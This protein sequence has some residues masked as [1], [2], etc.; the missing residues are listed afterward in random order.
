MSK[1]VIQIIILILICKIGVAQT[2]INTDSILFTT[3]IF[4]KEQALEVALEFDISEFIDQK[5]T[6]QYVPAIL[7][8]YIADSVNIRDSVRLKS[9]G[10][11]RLKKCLFPPYWINIKNANHSVDSNLKVNKIKVVSHCKASK[12]HENYLLKEFVAYKVFN[13]IT[14]YSFKVRLLKINYLDTGKERKER[15]NWAFMIEPEEVL[16]E[17]LEAYPLKLEKVSYS[18]TDTL[19]TTILSFFQYMIGNLDYSM[20]GRHNIKLVTLKDHK[21]TAIIPIPYDFD[22]TGIVDAYY[23]KPQ[24]IFELASIT[25]RYFFGMCRSNEVYNSVIQIYNEKEEEIYSYISSCD[26]LDKKTKKYV[27][28][29]IQDFYKEMNRSDFIKNYLRTT[30]E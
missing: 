4:D 30:C 3:D 24:P 12:M 29:Y 7:S 5:L 18:Q 19:N 15:T 28:S 22:Y 10:I 20:V 8:Y 14:D 2:E 25:E 1:K 13:I 11:F 26:F 27:L 21:K 17:R 9:R 16:A 6:K 23:A